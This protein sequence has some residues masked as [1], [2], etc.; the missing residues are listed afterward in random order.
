MATR[1]VEVICGRPSSDT[2]PCDR[3][4]KEVQIGQALQH[5]WEQKGLLGWMGPVLVAGKLDMEL[6]T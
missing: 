1:T 2:M 5:A 3:Y 6:G 4:D